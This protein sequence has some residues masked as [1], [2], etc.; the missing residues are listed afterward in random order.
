M[1]WLFRLIALGGS[2]VLC[3]LVLELGLRFA[4]GP[5]VHFRFPQERYQSDS[6]LGFSM[7]PDQV[8]FT[9]HRVVRTNS[10]GFRD[11]EYPA[12]SDPKTVRILALGDSQTFGNGL[13]LEESWPKQLEHL[14]SEADSQH[15]WQVINA[16]VSG[17]SPW[18]H[19]IIF[20]RA[21]ERYAVD[22]V[23]LAVYVNDVVPKPDELTMA[24]ARTNTHMKRFVYFVKRSAL[25]TA[26][27]RVYRAQS[28]KLSE[29]PEGDWER[30]IITGAPDAAVERGW[31]AVD[32]A[33][34]KIKHRAD[35]NGIPVVIL[36]LS[37][38]DQVDGS[39][40]ATAFNENV[41]EIAELHG[42][43]E[44]V[45]PLSALR[46]AYK[47]Y[48]SRLF[49]PWD[50][51]NSAIANSVIA[52]DLFAPVAELYSRR[53]RNLNRVEDAGAQADVGPRAGL[54]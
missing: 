52:G 49:I 35:A 11:A 31:V 12:R 20:E 1:S 17:T 50:G 27:L 5:P 4:V 23:I 15:S 10:A 37:R 7:V 44:F 46:H 8:A 21:L 3:A 39:L 13:D 33:V 28:S 26:V 30:N 34:S 43:D 51:H 18:Q 45:D 48:G 19:A 40:P 36:A 14:L 42:V 2:C 47:E 22:G 16:G 41:S 29:R 25:F 54:E 6:T 38:R 24:H 9:H 32:E 53:I